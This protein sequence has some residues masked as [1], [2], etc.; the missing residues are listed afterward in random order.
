MFAPT[1][2]PR[3]LLVHRS[4]CP[5]W[6]AEPRVVC[7]TPAWRRSG[8]LGPP[9]PW[10][11]ACS[12]Q[13][14]PEIIQ[15]H[16]TEWSKHT[17]PHYNNVTHPHKRSTHSQL[18]LLEI[19]QRQSFEIMCAWI[20]LHNWELKENK[21][22]NIRLTYYLNT[23]QSLTFAGR[24]CNVVTRTLASLKLRSKASLLVPTSWTLAMD[25]TFPNREKDATCSS[26]SLRLL[27]STK[28]VI[29]YW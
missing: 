2:L 11:C 21:H 7:R 24:S 20:I 23:L 5:S 25:I 3:C 29:V 18:R 27:P 10:G 12:E 16:S 28:F 15:T 17:P 14:H 13:T 4:A 22:T 9:A 6:R 26:F 8:S 1:P 19:V